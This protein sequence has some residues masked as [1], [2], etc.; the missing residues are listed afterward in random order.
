MKKTT[1]LLLVLVVI[2]PLIVVMLKS[3]KNEACGKIIRVESAEQPFETRTSTVGAAR[4]ENPFQIHVLTW[5]RP[6]SAKRLLDSLSISVYDGDVVDL[7][8]HIDGGAGTEETEKISCEFQWSHGSKETIKS[9]TN[10]GLAMSWFSAWRPKSSKEQAIIFEDDIVVS[11]LWYR[12]LKRAWQAYSNTS[13][14][15]GISLMRQTLVPKGRAKTMEIVNNNE[16]FL[17]K[18]VG[19]TG[20]S[21]HPEH[22]KTFTDWIHSVDYKTVNVFVPGL[23]TSNWWRGQL[24]KTR[25]WTQHFIYFCNKHKLYTLYIN[26]PGGKTL[27]ANMREAGAHYDGT[28]GADF[29]LATNISFHFPN[30][31]NKYNWEGKLWPI[32]AEEIAKV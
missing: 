7:I 10:H 27:A 23:V 8:I 24:S 30:E 3:L 19:S 12:W 14:L 17:Y 25:M 18:L 1:W 9:K 11:P 20:F 32:Y 16:P 6:A 2:L 26:L 15:A 5:N 29:P 13:D 31:L 28:K 21:P 4:S 22:W